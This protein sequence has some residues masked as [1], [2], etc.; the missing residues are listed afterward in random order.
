MNILKFI[1][2]LNCKLRIE[3]GFF[4][5]MQEEFI[6]LNYFLESLGRVNNNYKDDGCNN[7]NNNL[8]LIRGVYRVCYSF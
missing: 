5:Y 2:I 4:V 8:Y 1:F 6:F 7:N 3:N